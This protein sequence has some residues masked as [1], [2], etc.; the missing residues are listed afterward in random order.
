MNNFPYGYCGTTA[1]LLRFYLKEL[2]IETQEYGLNHK[3]GTHS[4]LKYND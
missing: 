3:N 4:I 1:S 2:G